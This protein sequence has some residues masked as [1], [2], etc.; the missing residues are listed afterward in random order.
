MQL[1][2]LTDRQR[3]VNRDDGDEQLSLIIALLLMIWIESDFS[4]QWAVTYYASIWIQHH[5]IVH[6]LEMSDMKVLFLYE[7]KSV[8]SI[9]CN[10]HYIQIFE[11]KIVR[12]E[13]KY[14]QKREVH[15]YEWWLIMS[16]VLLMYMCVYCIMDAVRGLKNI[17]THIRWAR[18]SFFGHHMKEK[19]PFHLSLSYYCWCDPVCHSSSFI[20]I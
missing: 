18:A 20:S 19:S 16:F 13:E 10:D 6:P 14:I 1:P 9:E 8:T 2:W 15:L 7:R 3:E 17:Y 4:S 5:H 12:I 11:C